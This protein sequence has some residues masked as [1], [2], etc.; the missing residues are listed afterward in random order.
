MRT[1]SREALSKGSKILTLKHFRSSCS[2]SKRAKVQDLFQHRTSL[3]KV[4]NGLGLGERV[5]SGG[6]QVSSVTA[7]I[8]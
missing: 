8:A 2:L 4:H 1:F 5:R 7:G 3:T 6:N